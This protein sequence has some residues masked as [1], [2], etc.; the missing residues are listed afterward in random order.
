MTLANLIQK[1]ANWFSKSKSIYF[2]KLP[3]QASK[4]RPIESGSTVPTPL[5]FV[6]LVIDESLL[7]P[8]CLYEE[9]LEDGCHFPSTHCFQSYWAITLLL[10]LAIL[11]LILTM[12][13]ELTRKSF[14]ASL[15]TCLWA[16]PS[17]HSSAL[18]WTLSLYLHQI[19]CLIIKYI[20]QACFLLVIDLILAA[21][22]GAA[23]LPS[24]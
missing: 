19:L 2:K 10:P 6:L 11:M 17:L 21:V 23:P 16:G 22:S 13:F 15:N 3:K 7:L 5:F 1:V 12:L 4:I 14:L 20:S 8:H 18:Y 24:L 9:S